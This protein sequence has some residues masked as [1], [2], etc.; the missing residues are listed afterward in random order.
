MENR[1]VQ[2]NENEYNKLNEKASLND[3]QIKDWLKNTTRN[4]VFSELTLH[5]N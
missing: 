3:S 2:L 5:S 4:V 1:I